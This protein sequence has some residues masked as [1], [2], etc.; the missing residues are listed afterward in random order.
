MII[1]GLNQD[2]SHRKIKND[3]QLEKIDRLN[4]EIKDYKKKCDELEKEHEKFNNKFAENE[5]TSS[6][7]ITDITSKLLD[8]EEHLVQLQ[9]EVSFKKFEIY[10]NQNYFF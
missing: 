3:E 6:Q 4:N 5:V 7:Q 10:K 2:L 1:E 8:R 9:N